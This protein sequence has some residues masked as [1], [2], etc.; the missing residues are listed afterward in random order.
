MDDVDLGGFQS[1]KSLGE[2]SGETIY[3]RKIECYNDI[4]WN[5]DL[6]ECIVSMAPFG[7]PVAVAGPN[8]K[9]IVQMTVATGK[10]IRIFTSSGRLISQFSQC[11]GANGTIHSLGWT[12]EEQLTT[13]YTDG[14]IC[15]YSIR[16]EK[17]LEESLGANIIDAAYY[18][19]GL[20]VLVEGCRLRHI[21]YRTEGRKRRLEVTPF[22]DV[23][24]TQP[25]HAI[26]C[27]TPES[28]ST[29]IPLQVYVSPTQVDHMSGTLYQVNDREC[30]DLQIPLSYILRVAVSPKRTHVATFSREG[31]INVS[32]SNMMENVINFDT[33]SFEPP[34]QLLWCG[35]DVVVGIWQPKQVK[36]DGTRSVLVLISPK[37]TAEYTFD[38]P[39]YGV[40]EA[41]CVRVITNT[42]CYVIERVPKSA[43]SIFANH[44]L[45]PGILLRDAFADYENERA[46]S[47]K[48]IRGLDSQELKQAVD[49]CIEAAGHEWDPQIQTELLKAAAYGKCFCK[50]YDA[51]TF[52]DQCNS[53]RVLNAVRRPDVGIPLSYGQYQALSPVVLID[54]LIQ[55]NLHFLAYKIC[56]YL[57]D[58]HKKTE[59]VL[60][61][62]AKA[63]VRTDAPPE[64]IVRGIQEKFQLCPGISYKEVAKMAT[65]A[66]KPA[67]AERLLEKEPKASDQ[68]ELLLDMGKRDMALE[69]AVSSG[70][71]DLVYRVILKMSKRHNADGKIHEDELFNSIKAH[72]L[73][74]DLFI[75]Y[76]E[77][78]DTKLLEK[79]YDAMELNHQLAFRSLRYYLNSSET[80]YSIKCGHLQAA[81]ERLPK[82]SVDFT[83]IDQQ[84]TLYTKQTTFARNDKI[85]DKSF[86]GESVAGTLRLMFKHRMSNKE[87][88]KFKNEF[89]IPQQMFFWVKLMALIE[90][91][92]WKELDAFGNMKKCPI[93]WKAFADECLKAGR[94][95]DAKKYAVRIEDYAK[96]CE[97]FCKLE[98]WAEAIRLAD[99]E[100]EPGLLEAIQSRCPADSPHR[101]TI[102]TL[103]SRY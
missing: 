30:R 9:K 97:M 18:P 66:H 19:D 90:F 11:E 28:L 24:L 7:G 47:V 5:V 87:I 50:T 91:G 65:A 92:Q 63:K 70:D 93:G 2:I 99:D 75:A 101:A 68:V 80:G 86:V 53:L 103:L 84:E 81:K 95:E 88:D 78:N 73:A 42:A 49:C 56:T 83:L 79:Y 27:L 22:A 1:W 98:M 39:A 34:N 36:P 54:R 32:R 25:P 21:I 64:E 3:Y 61:H 16:G 33:R 43:V 58:M 20:V 71:T 29:D 55:R 12:S 17:R 10:K 100:G 82:R 85:K 46:S 48:S 6:E 62:W 44:S 13:L 74:R 40:S 102:R 41:D 23:G 4:C 35:D 59:T 94:V 8:P 31:A 67:I 26:T 15:T 57:P 37:G 52:V 77:Y 89:D 51:D 96:R 69:K 60:I 76:C 14:L 72:P 38:G 45:D